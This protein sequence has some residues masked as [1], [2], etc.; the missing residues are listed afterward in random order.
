MYSVSQAVSYLINKSPFIQETLSHD[1]INTS[2]L[3]RFLQKDVNELTEKEVQIGAIQMAIKR[4]PITEHLTL[5]KS[6]SQFMRQLGD[7]IVRSDLVEYSY[8]ASNSLL[9]NQA[10]LL[11]IIDD[12][13]K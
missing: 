3:A 7:I 2:A 13:E 6:L 1:L 8:V 5:E 4:M 12:R 9:S 11:Q 10:K